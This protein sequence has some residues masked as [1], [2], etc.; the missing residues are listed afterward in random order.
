LFLQTNCNKGPDSD[1]E[2]FSALVSELR[3]AFNPHGFLLSSA[4]SPNKLI[5]DKGTRLLREKLL[6]MDIYNHRFLLSMV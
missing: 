2:A 3:E 1:K 6:L 4:V 5:I